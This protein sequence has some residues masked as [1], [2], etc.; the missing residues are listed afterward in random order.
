MVC[1]YCAMKNGARVLRTEWKWSVST[2]LERD[3]PML[4]DAIRLVLVPESRNLG[5]IE[6]LGSEYGRQCRRN[7]R[8]GLEERGD[9]SLKL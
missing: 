4:S 8:T 7:E 2:A 5:V 1:M 6:R 9:G 3:V